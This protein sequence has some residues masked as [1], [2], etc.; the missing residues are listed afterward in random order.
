[1]NA[2]HSCMALLRLVLAVQLRSHSNQG[3][4][5]IS[6]T[7][8]KGTLSE[9]PYRM[10]G[11]ALKHGRVLARHDMHQRGAERNTACRTT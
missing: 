11:A 6:R 10:V 1:M 5:G 8:V 4:R 7:G 3:R 9:R 2:L